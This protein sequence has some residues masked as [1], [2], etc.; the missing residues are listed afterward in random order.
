MTSSGNSGV[1]MSMS[2]IGRFRIA[3]RTQPPTKRASPFKARNTARVA[4]S[5]IQ[6]WGLMR[7]RS[8]RRRRWRLRGG[9]DVPRYDFTVAHMGRYIDT[10]TRSTE[11]D[12]HGDQ[13]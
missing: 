5:F 13:C 7:K 8:G 9:L 6:A 10:L 11:I 2:V 3:S 1:A 12:A 4:R